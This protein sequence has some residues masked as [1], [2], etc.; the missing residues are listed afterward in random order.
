MQ[1]IVNFD[2][3][4][5]YSYTA[6]VWLRQAVPLDRVLAITLRPFDVK[7]TNPPSR[8]GLPCSKEPGVMRTRMAL[9]F[10]A[11]QATAQQA[12][13]RYDRFGA[14]QEQPSLVEEVGRIHQH[15]VE[16]YAA[17]GTSTLVFPNGC[18]VYRKLAPAAT[19]GK[20]A[21]VFELLHGTNKRPGAIREIKLTRQVHP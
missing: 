21:Y 17:F 20:A 5:A 6:A 12:A 19:D 16:H 1:L 2:D 14:D 18:V 11:R 8:E 13:G 15:A 10:M 9:A 7:E 3:T 4:C